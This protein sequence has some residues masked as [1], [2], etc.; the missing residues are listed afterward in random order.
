MPD[1]CENII[2]NYL[3]NFVG[4]GGQMTERRSS[5]RRRWDRRF[6]LCII[7]LQVAILLL[8]LFGAG[9][10]FKKVHEQ[11]DLFK[12]EIMELLDSKSKGYR[13]TAGNLWQSAQLSQYGK[14]DMTKFP[15]E[16]ISPEHTW[17]N[18]YLHQNNLFT[19]SYNSL[20]GNREGEQE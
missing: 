14:V 12:L 18:K 2:K 1:H 20:E 19:M 17:F 7:R 9:L 13:A 5:Y 11:H 3:K 15:D 4:S 10:E 16:L 8:F 6:Y